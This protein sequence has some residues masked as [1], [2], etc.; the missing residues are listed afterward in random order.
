MT[1]AGLTQSTEDLNSPK[2]WRKVGFTLPGLPA[3]LHVNP[4]LGPPGPPALELQHPLCWVSGCGQQI[5]GLQSRKPICHDN[6][7]I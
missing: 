1:W 7:Y 5:V 6:H 3:E 4:V 2:T